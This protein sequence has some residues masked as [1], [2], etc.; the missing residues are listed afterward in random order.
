[1]TH[2]E[3][4]RDKSIKYIYLFTFFPVFYVVFL[5]ELL[6]QLYGQ[7]SGQKSFGQLLSRGQ[8]STKR[9]FVPTLATVTEQ[10]E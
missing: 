2:Q 9:T 6:S 10:T 8:K 3:E 1:M 4:K 5:L 7:K